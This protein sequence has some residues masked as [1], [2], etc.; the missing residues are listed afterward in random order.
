MT[1]KLHDLSE[2]YPSLRGTLIT[3]AFTLLK[4]GIIKENTRLLGKPFV[5]MSF[6]REFD[7][8]GLLNYA[9][10]L[11]GF[12][13]SAVAID[14]L[15]QKAKRVFDR[16]LNESCL[17][18]GCWRVKEPFIS[19]DQN[20]SGDEKSINCIYK[21]NFSLEG[22]PFESKYY[23]FQILKVTTPTFVTDELFRYVENQDGLKSYL[24]RM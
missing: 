4:K 21:I 13:E 15:N 17:G 3:P 11:D 12:E 22:G 9:W 19:A 8:D 16:S 6:L 5:T 20:P 23:D 14:S 18:G 10:I 1:K 7:C 2:I 24:I